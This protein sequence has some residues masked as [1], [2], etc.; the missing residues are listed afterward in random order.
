M[1]S[2]LSPDVGPEAASD[3]IRACGPA[4]D[5]LHP[6]GWTGENVAREFQHLERG[7]GRVC[8]QIISTR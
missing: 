5:A 3:E 6:M 4:A 7:H 2:R 1:L 8:C